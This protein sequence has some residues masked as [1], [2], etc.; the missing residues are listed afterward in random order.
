[1]RVNSFAVVEVV[2]PTLSRF[3]D[4]RTCISG[5][6]HSTHKVASQLGSPDVGRRGTGQ[7]SHE[8][9]ASLEVEVKRKRLPLPAFEFQH[10]SYAAD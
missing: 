7:H 10:G 8:Q 1:M 6:H 3:R 5:P 2:V 4:S 9:V